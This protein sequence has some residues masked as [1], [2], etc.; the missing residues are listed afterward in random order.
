MCFVKVKALSRVTSRSRTLEENV[1][2][3]NTEYFMAKV[4]SVRY[5]ALFLQSSLS[6]IRMPS[7]CVEM[8]IQ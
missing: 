6:R 5:P 1:E 7:V 4:N 3:G 2:L 8:R